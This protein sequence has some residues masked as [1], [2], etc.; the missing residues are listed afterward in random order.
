MGEETPTTFEFRCGGQ[1]CHTELPMPLAEDGMLVC[2]SDSIGERVMVKMLHDGMLWVYE[3]AG[4]TAE[5][6][7]LIPDTVA[8]KTLKPGDDYMT[9]VSDDMANA[10]TTIPRIRTLSL[11]ALAKQF[12]NSTKKLK[13]ITPEF[14]DIRSIF[15]SP[16]KPR[17]TKPGVWGAEMATM[18]AFG[19]FERSTGL[20]NLVVFMLQLSPQQQGSQ[21]KGHPRVKV[22]LARAYA[23]LPPGDS[24]FAS[25]LMCAGLV[26]YEEIHKRCG[27]SLGH[28]CE[29]N[30]RRDEVSVR[31]PWVLGANTAEEIR[32]ENFGINIKGWRG[33]VLSQ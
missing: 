30:C 9:T 20:Y 5:G 28:D 29:R 17:R 1:S 7:H 25:A 24:G 31:Y 11:R 18:I 8:W 33:Q 32:C 19:G 13:G 15:L 14:Q 12:L 10:P 23:G 16:K 4:G 2:F 21:T 27:R 26:T 22:V 3:P 6:A